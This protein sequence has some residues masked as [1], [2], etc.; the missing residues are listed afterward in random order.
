LRSQDIDSLSGHAGARI[1]GAVVELRLG[2]RL[3]GVGVGLRARYAKRDSFD[4]K[5]ARI[6][7]AESR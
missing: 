7:V 5:F 6:R 4:I 2:L 1:D 3:E